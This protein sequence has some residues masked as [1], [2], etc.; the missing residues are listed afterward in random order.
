MSLV[1]L[2]AYTQLSVSIL[3][4]IQLKVNKVSYENTIINQEK[5]KVFW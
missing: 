2:N 1:M 3:K 5:E 4:H